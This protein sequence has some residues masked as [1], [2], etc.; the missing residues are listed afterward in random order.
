MADN[1]IIIEIDVDNTQATKNIMDAQAALEEL[2]KEQKELNKQIKEGNEINEETVERMQEINE[3][4]VFQSDKLKANKKV[5]A[6]N[7][8]AQKANEDSL[9]SLRAQ[10]SKLLL[11][12]DNLS[13]KEREG[14]KGDKMLKDIQNLTAEISK[15]EE[16]SGRWQRS[17]G[18]YQKALEGTNLG[19][20]ATLMNNLSGGTGKVADAFKGGVTA[21]KAFSK[22]LLAMLANPIVAVIA[23]V[24]AVLMQLVNAIKKNDDAMTALNRV[25]ASFKPILDVFKIALDG[26][27]TA[28]TKIA[29]GLAN[30]IQKISSLIPGMK[31]LAEAEND[32]VV[33]TD[34]LEDTERTYTVE[35]AKRESKISELTAKSQQSQKYSFEQRK[36]FLEQAMK[37]EQEDLK[38]SKDIAKEKL[39]LAEQQAKLNKDTSDET[40]NQIAELKAAV[41]QAETAYNQGTKKIAKTLDSFTKEE[42]SKR[43]EAAK[44]AAAIA[45]ERQQI[46]EQAI[47]DTESLRISMIQNSVDKSIQTIT[48]QYNKEIS[49]VKEQLKDKSKLTKEAQ[50]SLNERLILLEAQKQNEISKINFEET[51]RQIDLYIETKNAELE[52]SKLTYQQEYEMRIDMLIKEA[53]KEEEILKQR[54]KN[55]EITEFQYLMFSKQIH[56]RYQTQIDELRHEYSMKTLKDNYEMTELQAKTFENSLKKELYALGENEI[57]K[58][59]VRLKYAQMTYT[60][61]VNLFKEYKRMDTIE[62][63]EPLWKAFFGT[64]EE[65]KV[66]KENARANMFAARDEIIS[67]QKD[68]KNAQMSLNDSIRSMADSFGDVSSQLGS[69]FSEISSYYSDVAE[70]EKKSTAERKRAAEMELQFMRAS[71]IASTAQALASNAVSFAKAIEGASTAAAATGPLAPIT[72]AA[73]IAEMIGLILSSTTSVMSAINQAKSAAETASKYS[74]STG[75]YV[76]GEGTS[77]SDSIHAR[78]SN[79]ESVINAKSTKMFYPILD[80]INQAG[81]GAAFGSTRTNRFANGGVATQTLLNIQNSQSMRRMLEEAMSNIHPVVSVREIAEV[82]HHVEVKERIATR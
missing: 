59:K 80:A 34:R 41:Y 55:E 62:D 58:G 39:R 49:K 10:L 35:H 72:L 51:K 69:L 79:G 6:D 19:K 9:V 44:A 8:K 65:W 5:L 61:A 76:Q 32:L 70:N 53:K 24:A 63:G 1:T 28:I 56:N 20:Y 48:L 52:T 36:S 18:H 3:Q 12:Y 77:T 81:G 67:I 2:K 75:G 43:K 30:V 7:V 16:A 26:I 66:A 57:E 40:K 21:V 42:I 54:L 74:F 23:A 15:A 50:K 22:Q 27:V 14:A 46:E 73:N 25:M 78:L 64:E 29:N 45:K 82:Q 37:L 47:R 11:A 68:I 31:Q 4:I 13:K 33:V 17:V 38:A 60:N 71:I